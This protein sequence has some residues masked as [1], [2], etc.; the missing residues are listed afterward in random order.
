MVDVALRNNM[1]LANYLQRVWLA[2][3]ALPPPDE[4]SQRPLFSFEN[5]NLFCMFYVSQLL[6]VQASFFIQH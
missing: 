5:L 6:E 2:S 4:P 3:P 1:D